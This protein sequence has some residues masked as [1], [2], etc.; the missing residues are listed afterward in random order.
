MHIVFL[1]DA[2]DNQN[3]GVHFYTSNLIRAL[4]KLDKKNK[5]SFIHQKENA[6]FKNTNHHILPSKKWL[7]Y[8]SFR[9]FHLIPKLLKKLK[10]DIVV[11]PCHIGPFRTPKNSK[12]ITIIHDL[13][14]ILF[15]KFHIKRSTIIHKL[16]LGKVLKNANLILTPSETTKSDIL[17]LY[18]T[19][20]EIVVT[21][22]GAPIHPQI[23]TKPEILKNSTTPYLLFIGTI[24]PRKNLSILM[25]A[26]SDLKNN[27]KIP[28]KL[29][30][31]GNIGWKS[32]EIIK[33][34]KS[35]K[36]IIITSYLT[37]AEKSYLY[38]NADIF[39]YPSIYEGFG[40]PPLEAMSYGIPVIC[41][42]G[43]S[44]KEVFEHHS[45]QFEPFDLEKL[46]EH[47]LAIINNDNLRK[48]LAQEG[49]KYSQIFTWEKTAQTILNS[50]E[51]LN[52]KT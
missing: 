18:K 11:E 38:Q 32:K 19:N 14:P 2:I 35:N 37:E 15:P 24:E 17:A 21:S 9:K 47:I 3:A 27:H 20:T 29:I 49:L 36:D 22:E 42:N 34:A 1:A 52:V 33:Q 26:F 40:L 43:G 51:N 12:K 44:L 8:E 30:L 39:I 23:Q 7:G 45:L 50:L 28:H 4:L 13:T 25:N 31:G 16:L 10:P 48:S 5:Y 41:S 46:K 6:F